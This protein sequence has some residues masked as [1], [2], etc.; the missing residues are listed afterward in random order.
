MHCMWNP[1]HQ[2]FH[3]W[4]YL[5]MGGTQMSLAPIGK[6]ML[7]TVKCVNSL[8][9]STTCFL[10]PCLL[11]VYILQSWPFIFTDKT[12]LRHYTAVSTIPLLHRV[13]R[14][15]CIYAIIIFMILLI[16]IGVDKENHVFPKQCICENNLTIVFVP[17][18]SIH[19][20]LQHY[21]L[22]I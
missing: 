1:Y 10:H 9:L 15:S 8:G 19:L 6:L 12:T 2:I 13:N 17:K 3:C 5:P 4:W 7:P 16:S 22:F 14:R 21:C 20:W 11:H 18:P